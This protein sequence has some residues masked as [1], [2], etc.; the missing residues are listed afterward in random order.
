MVQ[1]VDVQLWTN[2]LYTNACSDIMVV[3]VAYASYYHIIYKTIYDDEKKNENDTY[4][5]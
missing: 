4:Y 1:R 2:Y 3:V 5:V